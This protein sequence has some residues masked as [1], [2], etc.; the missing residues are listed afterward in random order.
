M[1]SSLHLAYRATRRLTAALEAW[2]REA[3]TEGAT[4]HRWTNLAVWPA[5]RSATVAG[6]TGIE[7]NPLSAYQVEDVLGGVH[8]DAEPADIRDVRN[9]NAALDLANRAAIRPDFEWSQELLRRINAQVIAG[10]PNDE[11]GEYRTIEVNVGG[12]YQPPDH[13]AVPSL[14]GQLISWLRTSDNDHGLVLAGLA[15]LNVVS[16]HPWRDGNGRASRVVGSLMLMRHGISAPELVNIESAIRANPRAYV[17]ALQA[18]H[19]PSYQPDRHSA[20][21]WLEYFA[22]LSVDRL[23]LRTRLEAA[24]A[25][26][27]GLISMALDRAGEPA[28]WVAVTLAGASGQ[29]RTAW[30][31]DALGL[32]PA[33]ARALLG[34]AAAAGWLIPEGDRRGRRYRAG[35]RLQALRLRSP[36]VLD[37]LRQGAPLDR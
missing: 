17:D 23:E 7:G 22:E 16:I 10:L 8:V 33:R 15:H 2:D 25:S 18:S 4:L 14:M 28:S 26:D 34:E 6:S 20:T 3:R 31:S 29:V 12:M 36:E 32:S 24:I 19:G 35:P 27:V 5:A 9:Y 13:L 37:R 21:P 30:V 11:G 1:F